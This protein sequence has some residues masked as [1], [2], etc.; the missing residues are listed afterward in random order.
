MSRST[1]ALLLAIGSTAFFSM[2]HA[3]VRYLSGEMDPLEIAFLRSVFGVV[4]LAP[5]LLRV[6]WRGF[7]VTRPLALGI[8]GTLSGLS[9]MLWFSGLALVPIAEA[10]ALSFTNTIFATLGAVI[11]LGEPMRARRWTAVV[12]GMIGVLVV[13][14]PGIGVVQVG[15]LLVL[16]SALIWGSVMCL[17]KELVKTETPAA[18]TLWTAVAVAVMTAIPA[19]FV[20]RTPSWTEIALLAVMGVLGSVGQL[21]WTQAIKSVDATLIIPTDFTRL[22]WAGL[23]G[24]LAFAEVPDLWTWVG[25]ALIVGSTLYI[26][27]REAHLGRQR[28]RVKDGA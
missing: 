15:S 23:I 27:L 19:A 21:M 18:V 24:Y 25:S 28:D 13:L 3:L 17:V 26:G 16:C 11:V 12:V 20:W 14:R 8:R 5:L 6:G 22:V 1:T 9:M 7:A 2:M 4:A 10:T